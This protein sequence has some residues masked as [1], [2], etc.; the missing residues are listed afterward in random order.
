[1]SRILVVDDE[2]GYRQNLDYFFTR[3]GH[4][5]KTAASGRAGIRLGARFRPEVLIVDWMLKNHIHGLHVSEVLNMVVPD[6]QTIL[7]TGFPSQDLRDESQKSRMCAF[8][9]KP[10]D[11]NQIETAVED[12]LVAEKTRSARPPV[13]VVEVDAAGNLIYANPRA[14]ELFTESKACLDVSCL[15][16]LFDNADMPDLDAAVDQWIVASPRAAGPH[17]WRLRSEEPDAD[18]KRLV[19]LL[20]PGDPHHVY[21]QLIQMLLEVEDVTLPRHRWKGQFLVVEPDSLFRRLALSTLEANQC[22][23]Y[24]AENG[25]EALRLLENNEKVNFVILEYD[26]PEG[27]AATLVKQIRATRPGITI[28]G[29]SSWARHSEFAALGVDLFLL[30]PWRIGNLV[31]LLAE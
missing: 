1:M 31:E 29:N 8:L 3:Q 2:S 6:M 9:E 19:I 21:A 4:R 16:D 30:K 26:L 7:I 14:W 12:A 20:A 17:Y 22:A 13:G 25:S 24:A 15:E 27:D 28:I 23:C 10:F 11:L 5:V 18:G